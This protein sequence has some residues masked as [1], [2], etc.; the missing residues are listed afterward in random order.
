MQLFGPQILF[1][2]VLSSNRVMVLYDSSYVCGDGQVVGFHFNA[3]GACHV[4]VSGAP[5]DPL[6]L[7]P[8]QLNP[9]YQIKSHPSG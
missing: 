3:L 8:T 6:L 2:R 5:I 1:L 7:A 9:N 4:L